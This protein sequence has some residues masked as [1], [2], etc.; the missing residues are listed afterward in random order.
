L[1]WEATVTSTSGFG[2][3]LSLLD[4][5]KLTDGDH[6]AAGA[7]GGGGG[8]HL[9]PEEI[10]GHNKLDNEDALL[11]ERVY[12]LVM[13][14][15]KDDDEE[16]E[17]TVTMKSKLSRLGMTT[18]NSNTYFLPPQVA[19]KQMECPKYT[20]EDK[21]PDRSSVLLG[22]SVW[23]MDPTTTSTT[24]SD[25]QKHTQQVH[26]NLYNNRASPGI[27]T[28]VDQVS[29]SQDHRNVFNNVSGQFQHLPSNNAVSMGARLKE[30]D[31]QKPVKTIIST[32]FH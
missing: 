11:E 12:R 2:R 16:L 29:S 27:N 25:Q 24:P 14:V 20:A 23:P 18:T 3:D 4:R 1:D 15:I 19:I 21:L 30:K 8:G 13:D 10:K 31:Q 32:F 26:H 22:S 17:E 9:N 6:D 7:G 5:S 28:K